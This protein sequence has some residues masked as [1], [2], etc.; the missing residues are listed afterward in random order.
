MNINKLLKKY[1]I[2]IYDDSLDPSSDLFN[3]DY[4][5]FVREL[6][7]NNLLINK[8]QNMIVI[9][10]M[11]WLWTIL[12]VFAVIGGVTLLQFLPVAGIITI[13]AVYIWAGKK[14]TVTGLVLSIVMIL[15]NLIVASWIDILFWVA[16]LIILIKNR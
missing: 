4:D 2:D 13:L 6:V 9:Q 7:T 3:R 15:A 10:V 1:H 16:T 14:L 8:G 5:N 11:F 12:A